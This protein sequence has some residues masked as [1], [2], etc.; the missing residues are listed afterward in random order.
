MLNRKNGK[1]LL[2]AILFFTFLMSTYQVKAETSTYQDETGKTYSCEAKYPILK[3]I[4]EA[5]FNIEVNSNGNGYR[6]SMNPKKVKNINLDDIEVVVQCPNNIFSLKGKS[7]KD[8]KGGSF[9]CTVS[10]SHSIK[11]T[12]EQDGNEVEIKNAK[13]EAQYCWARFEES[14]S[15]EGTGEAEHVAG[16]NYCPV[17]A[18][19]NPVGGTT[20]NCSSPKNKFEIAFCEAKVGASKNNPK[21]STTFKCDI[22]K[23]TPPATAKTADEKYYLNKSYLYKKEDEIITKGNYTYH[24]N[25][26]KDETKG[27][28]I[29][30]KITCEEAVTVEYGA[31]VASKAGMCFTY[32]VKVTSRVSCHLA[33]KP[34]PPKLNYG[35]C[36]PVP[37]CVH[38][39]QT[40]EIAEYFQGGPDER[41]DS[42]IQSCDG[43]KYTKK[44]S[45]KCYKKIYGNT[46][47]TKTTSNIKK[48][49]NLSV[50]R[51]VDS[52]CKPPKDRCYFTGASGSIQWKC[53]DGVACSTNGPGADPQYEGRWYN[54]HWA[55]FGG[56]DKYSICAGNGIYKR[57]YG[58]N[59]Y[60]SD[61]CYWDISGCGKGPHYLN[62][63]WAEYDNYQNTML[64]NEVLNSCQ[65]KATCTTST[66]EF[67]ISVGYT[68]SDKNN[69]VEINYPYNTKSKT[70]DKLS[71]GENMANT[72]SSFNT[73]LVPENETLLDNGEKKQ[74]GCYT[75]QTAQDL[76]HAEWTFAGTWINN[77]T[78]EIS[79]NPKKNNIGWTEMNNAFC[80]PLNAKN[81]NQ[82]WWN[83]YMQKTLK[84]QGTSISTTLYQ[85]KCGIS[86]KDT[87]ITKIKDVVQN[88][89]KSWNI[90]AKTTKFGYFNWSINVQCFYALNTDIAMI[91]ETSNSKAKEE[92]ITTQESYKVRTVDLNDL[93]PAPDGKIHQAE[94]VGRDPGFNWTTFATN[95]KNGPYTSNPSRYAKQVQTLGENIYNDD[96]LD[97]YFELDK[98]AISKLK[99]H[100]Y[101]T[102]GEEN[103]VIL[104]DNK[105]TSYYSHAIRDRSLNPKVPEEKPAT[106][107]NNLENWHSTK[108][109]TY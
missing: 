54:T 45:E 1:R 83:W 51:I 47:V 5:N 22:K 73:T 62:P 40:G 95:E 6:I 16:N 64:Y 82:K 86:A 26:E 44:C 11:V 70:A 85:E 53:K 96:Y 31:P 91:T 27:E 106:T 8:I 103:S 56:K 92:C 67:V 52:Q 75:S 29:K 23:I 35:Y 48:N 71:S 109:Q 104:R 18:P 30:C 2:F 89:I 46:Q 76:Y 58:D 4:K 99:G 94:E 80:V 19:A 9:G 14:F 37:K 72:S 108:C 74:N 21:Q 65:A 34:N 78:G 107:C 10:A 12:K 43:G 101:S 50:R 3:E 15:I 97:Y 24:Y 57:W 100:K 7:Y 13:G 59:S 39:K 102:F 90:N 41:F 33:E 28:A 55:G 84:G 20:I 63:N 49:R 93:F 81:V 105:I 88:D 79:Y 98:R 25:G 68:Q 77:K 61:T 38:I 60:C 66:A 17:V 42:C 87:S 32:K 36:E 69:Y